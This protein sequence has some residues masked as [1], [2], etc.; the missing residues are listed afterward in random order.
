MTKF[1]VNLFVFLFLA[2]NTAVAQNE[3]LLR[4]N[5]NQILKNKDATVGIAIAG[6]DGQKILSI[7]G[8]KH[9]P[10]QSV[11]KFPIAL[12][13]LHQVDQG[14]ISLNKDI[15]LTKTNLK[16]N[17]YSPIHDKYPGGVTL[18]L[19]E[20]LKYSVSKSDNIATDV[21]LKLIG[22]PTV[23]EHYIKSNGIRNISI[24]YNEKE[25][26][27]RWEN[28]YRNW[29]TPVASNQLLKTFFDNGHKQ[30]SK[31][32]HQFI[33]KAMK[34]TTTGQNSIRAGIPAGATVAHKTGYSGINS[35]GITGALNDIGIVFLP[36]GKYFYLSVFVCNSKESKEVNQKIISD[37]GKYAWDYFMRQYDD[38][39][40]K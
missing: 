39:P 9:F 14:R 12:T 1:I 6:D 17:T 31:K 28:Q 30:L 13:I 27:S 23:V 25:Q 2:I 18:K 11:F 3:N 37:V 20:L 16:E 10:M 22:G 21:L 15:T 8:D 32:S 36:N 38:K 40:E 29:I 34:T 26:N 33:W 35:K 24:K 5:I 4:K 7:N 19:S